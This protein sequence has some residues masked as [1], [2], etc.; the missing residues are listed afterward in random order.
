MEADRILDAIRRIV[1]PLLARVDYLA[2]YPAKIVQQ[3]GDGT[4]EVT[5]DDAR[6][7][8]MTRV[9]LRTFIPGVEVRV[10]QGA[11]V[12]VGFEGGDP[13]RP[14][15]QLFESGAL[16]SLKITAEGNVD[17]RAKTVTLADGGLPAARQGDM[18]AVGGPTPPG[19]M[20]MFTPTAPVP[21]MGG[22]PGAMIAAQ[23]PI[24]GTITFT[25]ALYGIITSGR[26]TVKA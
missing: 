10:K 6:M 13:T 20:C 4:L 1:R 16:D 14:Y 17:L 15:A 2:L 22:I 23:V 19:A 9:P 5:P 3:T 26:P 21:V 11:R 12:L 8:G 18:V 24:P 7:P 25:P